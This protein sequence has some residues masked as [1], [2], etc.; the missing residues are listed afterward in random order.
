MSSYFTNYPV[1][2]LLATQREEKLKGRMVAPKKISPTHKPG[3]FPI[4]FLYRCI[5][6]RMKPNFK[7]SLWISGKVAEK[8]GNSWVWY[9]Y[10]FWCLF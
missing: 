2:R 8:V 3:L 7:L 5:C 10:T 6:V 4:Y 9:R 1:F